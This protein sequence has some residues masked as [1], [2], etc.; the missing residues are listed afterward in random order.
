MSND[1]ALFIILLPNDFDKEI[2]TIP[3]I[4]SVIKLTTSI[5]TTECRPRSATSDSIPSSISMDSNSKIEKDNEHSQETSIQSLCVTL[6]NYLA[7]KNHIEATW[8]LSD[9]KKTYQVTFH[10][11][12]GV[13]SDRIL[14]DLIN[15]GIG[16][17]NQSKIFVLPTTFILEGPSNDKKESI[18]TLSSTETITTNESLST[19]VKNK[20][21]S[22][23]SNDLK[24]SNKIR[25]RINESNFKKSVRARLMVHQVVASIRASTV[26]SFDFVLLICLASMLAALGLLENST[27][28]IV[29]SMLVSPLMNP[30]LGFVFGLSVREHSLWR[31]GLRNELIG[32]IIC[33]SC[34][35]IL[36]LLTTFAETKW[37]ASTSFPTSEMKSRGD[38]KRLWVGVL[39]ALPSG[40]GVALS[41]LGG[42][43]GSLVGVAISA[44]L[45]PPAVNCGL[46][47]AYALLGIS[48]SNIA[49]AHS[50][51]LNNT[52][53]EYYSNLNCKT[54]INNDYQ[55]LY[56]CNLVREAAALAGCSL[57]LTIINIICIIIM[58]LFIL[59]IKEVVPL[60]Q[61]NKDIANFF[62]HDVKVAR[63]YNKINYE[64]NLETDNLS[65]LTIQQSQLAQ[66][67]MNRWKKFK[68]ITSHNNQ[69]HQ[70]IQQSS[71][72]ENDLEL[73][74]TKNNNN[75]NNNNNILNIDTESCRKLF[76]LRTFAKE[77]DLDI[78]D[79]NDYDLL[80]SNSREKVR[81]LINDLIDIYQ[82]IPTVFI[83]LFR[84]Q[85]CNVQ[86]STDKEHMSFYQEII[87]LLPPKWYQLFVREQERRRMISWLSPLNRTNSLR[88]PQL[89][90]FRKSISEFNKSS[91]NERQKMRVQFQRRTSLPE[92]SFRLS[93]INESRY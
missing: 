29:A 50:S 36:G 8:M 73:N 75:N 51:S 92:T 35:F 54:Y 33:I 58:A 41:V 52:K 89:T 38:I 67:I 80:N 65:T 24:L 59:R 45:L 76:R 39:I 90:A 60:H 48:F 4:S 43:T 11:E 83:D 12:F 27:V 69:Q 62:H 63:D 28:I 64:D 23:T 13:V 79:K 5:P 85:P 18:S 61:P 20:I 91:K 57:L 84:L 49:A 2:S 74:N 3:T 7:G 9:N 88:V 53:K 32:L 82:D 56:T 66:S 1:Y 14:Q 37:G 68:S 78:F 44:S 22:T 30:I 6:T 16:T 40:A 25:K 17:R 46:L 55:P 34:G 47:F 81:L 72:I 71:S 87:E 31:R 77:Y 19:N 86:T 21:N 15:C 70:E 42:N 93:E 10:V 26:L